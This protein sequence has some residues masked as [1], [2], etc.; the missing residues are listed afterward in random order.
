[1]SWKLPHSF[2]SAAA[3]LVLPDH[4][5]AMN[6]PARLQMVAS[7]V[8]RGQTLVDIGTDHAR[9][10]IA[11]VASGWCETAI[12]ADLRS[13]PLEGAS[14]N[15]ARAGLVGRVVPR[16]GDGFDVLSEG[17]AGV[18]TLAGMGGENIGELIARGR[19]AALG[20]E[21]MVVQANTNPHLV[22]GALWA[23]GWRLEDERLCVDGARMFLTLLARAGQ[24]EGPAPSLSETML[25]SF[26]PDRG[27]VLYEAWLGAL[28]DHAETRLEGVRTGGRDHS[29]IALCEAVLSLYEG[30]MPPRAVKK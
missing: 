18:A 24:R 15:I 14:D 22:R 13:R 25:G 21:T 8:P 9:L 11:L 19:P 2:D 12:A 23:C 4:V 5:L 6:L 29:E 28:F 7:M 16:L 20:V 27:G 17:E 10:P 3:D 26:L 30:L 1:M